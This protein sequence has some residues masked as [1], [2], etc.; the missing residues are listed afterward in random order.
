MSY[1]TEKAAA[2]QA[3]AAKAKKFVYEPTLFDAT[4]ATYIK[5]GAIV[6][7][8]QP[9]GCPKN[10]TMGMTYVADAETG[11][12]IGMVCLAS[13]QPLSRDAIE[14]AKLRN[15]AGLAGAPA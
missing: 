7:K 8:A 10:G 3:A 2:D 13:L 1:A 15:A 5:R 4:Q 6:V 11:K 9:A 12:F 14:I